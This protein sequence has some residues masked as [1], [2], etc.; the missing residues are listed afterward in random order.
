[1]RADRPHGLPGDRR[2][3]AAPAVGRRGGVDGAAGVLRDLGRGGRRRRL[4]PGAA[5]PAL[6][7][8]PPAAPFPR[9][10]PL[11]AGR[12]DGEAALGGRT[13]LRGE[14]GRPPARSGD[15]EILVGGDGPALSG[16]AGG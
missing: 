10:L 13:P 6:L 11:R 8:E 15:A 1:S 3:P 2:L 12:A 14:G 9:C 4:L 5:S 16:G 7:P